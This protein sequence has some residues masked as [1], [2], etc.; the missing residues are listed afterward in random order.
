MRAD[1]GAQAA[2]HP[3]LAARR[4]VERPSELG[5][6]GSPAVNAESLGRGRCAHGIL[7]ASSLADGSGGPG[8]ETG[9]GEKAAGEAERRAG[10]GER[11]QPPGALELGFLWGGARGSCSARRLF[12]R[13][14]RPSSGCR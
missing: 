7:S 12:A 3:S 14:R 4:Q 10:A 9:S 8:W 5:A 2:G 13:R 6:S 11:A 1:R